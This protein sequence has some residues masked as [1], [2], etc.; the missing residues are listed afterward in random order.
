MGK[1]KSSQWSAGTQLYRQKRQ[2]KAVWCHCLWLVWQ[3]TV[4]YAS[5]THLNSVW[6]LA[7]AKF[8]LWLWYL[9]V[10]S[11]SCC[12]HAPLQT[13]RLAWPYLF[14]FVM[15]RVEINSPNGLSRPLVFKQGLKHVGHSCSLLPA[16]YYFK[17]DS[18]AAMHKLNI[19]IRL[20]VCD[21]D[22][23][24][25]CFPLLRVCVHVWRQC[26]SCDSDHEAGSD[27]ARSLSGFASFSSQGIFG[28]VVSDTLIVMGRP[29]CQWSA[30]ISILLGSRVEPRQGDVTDRCLDS[31]ADGDVR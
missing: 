25:S 30:W 10:W 21:S 31:D 28:I 14:C 12:W 23:D 3:V 11:C 16:G 26:Q 5:K 4:I 9:K 22:Y 6:C 29:G 15:G 17:L 13:W 1:I 20:L 8:G 19:A 18:S 27:P 2:Q 7:H 24:R